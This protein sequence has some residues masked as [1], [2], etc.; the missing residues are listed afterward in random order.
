MNN[1][2]ND[3]DKKGKGKKETSEIKVNHNPSYNGNNKNGSFT[4]PYYQT[5]LNYKNDVNQYYNI[6][7]HYNIDQ[8]NNNLGKSD[9][10]KG[11]S[12]DEGSMRDNLNEPT[13]NEAQKLSKNQWRNLTD[14]FRE[15]SAG[16]RASTSQNNEESSSTIQNQ[17]QRS[18]IGGITSFAKNIAKNLRRTEEEEPDDDH[19][20]HIKIHFHV[21]LP[22]NISGMGEPFVI[23][24][25]PELGEWSEFKVKLRQFKRNF[26]T[27]TTYWYSEPI[28]IPVGRFQNS[29]I[30]RY[31]YVIR[32]KK[33][34]DMTPYFYEGND[35]RDDRVLVMYKNQFDVW[36]IGNKNNQIPNVRI[37]DYM[38][39][40]IIYNSINP[41]NFKEAILEYDNILKDNTG[42]T[43]SVTN[44]GFIYRYKQE[45][46]V[47][48]RLFLIFLLGHCSSSNHSFIGRTEL[49]RDFNPDFLFEVIGEI[50][51]DTFPSKNLR[52]VS[53]GIELLVR[54]DID[55]RSFIWL[56][57]FPIAQYID[58]KYSFLDS[59]SFNYDADY[60]EQF[61][62]NL[63]L[64]IPY[65]DTIIDEDVYAKI[66]KWLINHC[67]MKM[68]SIIWELIVHSEKIDNQICPYLVE[69]VGRLISKYDS[70]ELNK[71]FNELPESIRTVVTEP[72]R[73]K[74]IQLLTHG[75]F[76]LWG[77]ARAEAVFTL[78]NSLHLRW[79]KAEY[80]TVLEIMSNLM[81]YMLLN[82]FPILL[83]NW[84]DKSK[85]TKDEKISQICIQWY[86]RLMDQMA[87]MSSKTTSNEE[88][89]VTAVFKNLSDV[90]I[91]NEKSVMNE[92][93]DITYNRIKHSSEFLI[94]S[95][96]T[97][98]ANMDS[99]A[100]LVFKKVIKEKINPS[101]Q[102]HDEYLLKKMR[103]ICGCI[104]NDLNIPNK[105]CEEILSHIM[106]CLKNNSS[107]IDFEEFS[108]RLHL[109]LF[110]SADF[111]T[112]ILRATGNVEDFH[113]HPHIKAAK[114]AMIKLA[115]MIND[116]FIDLHLLQ[117]L[118][119]RDD[120]F[121]HYYLNSAKSDNEIITRK[122]LAEVRKKCHDYE[123]KLNML[124]DF[125]KT[126]CQKANDV[127]NY[128][129]E[130]K[131]RSNNL[132]KISLKE[133]L[134]SDHWG[135]H[136]SIMSIVEDLN[137]FIK[138]QTFNNIFRKQITNQEDINVRFIA[139]TLI[140]NALEEYKA[141]C[142]QYERWENLE[143]SKATSFWYK[144]H[145]FDYEL[146]LMLQFCRKINTTD[147][148]F[149]RTIRYLSEV[150]DWKER[151][152][153]LSM[154]LIIFK[155][156]RL[157]NDWLEAGFADLN[158]DLSLG[159][160]SKL[161]E[162]F[163]DK[164]SGFNSNSW[165]FIKELSLSDEFIGFLRIIAEHDM[166]NLINGV[167]E[168]SDTRLIQ[169]D[170]VSSLIQVKQCLLP[171]MT[172]ANLT[173]DRYLKDLNEIIVRNPS[174]A[175]KLTL[176]NSNSM[177]LQNMYK[178]ISNRGEVTKEK[179][180][181]AVNIGVY[182]FVKEEKDDECTL[183]L[184]YHS[185]SSKSDGNYDVNALQDLRGRALLISKPGGS[186]DS[187]NG[188]IDNTKNIMEE[189][190]SQFDIAQNII[191]IMNKLTQL[192]HFEY[193]KYNESAKGTN[194]LKQISD[195]LK[196]ELESWEDIVNKAQEN[197][198]YLTF[199][200]SRHILAFYDFYT[201]TERQ[202]RI[203]EICQT[204]VSFVNRKAILP[205]G[206]RNRGF[207]CR[208]DEYYQILKEIGDRLKDIFEKLPKNP[209]LIKG[210]GERVVSDVVERGKLFVAACNDKFRVPNIIMSF[211]ANHGS[212]PEPWQL[213]I[214][215]SSTTAEELS[216]FI[217]RCFFASKNGYK[218][219]LFCIANL[220]LL[221]FELQYDL[222]NN[223][224]THMTEVKDYYL[225]LICCSETGMNHHILD[226]FSEN[227]H[228]T[229]GLSDA[230]MK[231]IYRE[232]CP[233]VVCVTSELSGQGKTEW[234]KQES[235]RRHLVLKS[236]LISDG[237][238]YNS[239]VKQLK[240]F[241]IRHVNSLHINI[242]SAD[243][244]GEVNIFL[245]Q[246]ITLGIVSNNSDIA[247]RIDSNV[248]IEV[249][250]SFD[251]YL[252]KS[253]PFIN[254]LDRPHLVWNVNR[255]IVSQEIHNPIQIVCN[256]LNLYERG[257]LDKK[258]IFFRSESS[259]DDDEDIIRTPLN[260]ELCQQ[261]L[262]KYF[263]K[264][265]DAGISS[266]RFL[267]IFINVLADQLIRLSS[268]SFFEV[269][270][271]N[272]MIREN[273]VRSTLLNTL[274]DVSKDFATKSIQTRSAQL[275]EI[276]SGVEIAQL[277]NIAQWDDSNHLLVFFMSQTPDSI[278]SLY[279]DKTKV[280]N[281]VQ[282]LLKS[283]YIDTEEEWK[284]L[285]YHTMSSE[286]LLSTLECLARK[287]MHKID[288]PQ[289]ALSVDNLLKMALMLLRT[290]ANI[291]VVVCGEAGCGKTS[292]IGFLAGVVEVEFRALNLHAGITEQN[293]KAFMK[294]SD[295][296]AQN[297]EIWLFF[298]EINTCNH[299]GLLADLIAHRMLDGKPI[300]PNIR[301]FAACNP[302]RIRKKSISNVG[303]K[304][305]NV[306]FE[307]QSR[308]VYEVKPLPDQILDYVWDY[309]R[310][311]PNDEKIYI[312][313]MVN[314]QLEG[315]LGS[316]MLA[317]LL[318][319]SQEFIRNVEESYS[320]S[321]RDV[322]RAIKLVKFFHNSLQNRPIN[323]KDNKKSHNKHPN[324][325]IRSYILALGLCYQ[326]RLY[327]RE[328]RKKY[329]VEMCK[330]FLREKLII[331]EQLFD[332]V[333]KE[334]QMD[335]IKRMT[336]P[337]NTAFNEALLENVLVIIVCILNRI[338]LFIVGSPGSSKSLAIRLVH[339]NL[340]GSDSNDE[341]FRKLPQVFF[342][343]HQGSSSSTSDG[344]EKVFQ[345]AKA[346]QETSSK[347]FPVISVVLLDEVGLAET[348]P[349]NPLKV[350]HSLLEP[351]Y[352]ADGPTVS[353]VGISNWRLD[354]SKSSRALLVQRP[355]FDLDDLI[356]T[357]VRLLDKNNLE[358]PSSE[359]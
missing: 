339:Q 125:Y 223:I 208:R 36:M 298:D 331:R 144:V 20:E 315:T 327:D 311:Q 66:A 117:N 266:F 345:K 127:E 32:K 47:H 272:L 114:I 219:C 253:L 33:N 109:S 273:N 351:S 30:V 106:T 54:R 196:K 264:R 67:N 19:S 51:P 150:D 12:T 348:S 44:F 308:L 221:D 306:R 137:I 233:K 346:Y 197:C 355:K 146:K 352:P 28:K 105:L 249:A 37:N 3:D 62:K 189:F 207:N 49:S 284:L 276:A 333:I 161:F 145:N 15:N 176:C 88:S 241:H 297:K 191:T 107:H 163:D 261:L 72:Y 140:R 65:I 205:Y 31:K 74:T 73:K 46:S 94:F 268:S 139:K 254:C 149:I 50:Q 89:Y 200:P 76:S 341:Y 120:N 343:P 64:I 230:A 227:V 234:I 288:Y 353:V 103:V 4:A 100:I 303:L 347:E 123:Q 242:I 323:Q 271:L 26:Q 192:G 342:I 133:T 167:D 156:R 232:L 104:N 180:Q 110:D 287:T 153:Y 57:I 69:R 112:V 10:D 187:G 214:C 356:E 286:Q 55:R 309:G 329:R 318:F 118:I 159:K 75:Q 129:D 290:R 115:T 108:T 1:Q 90:S 226:Q 68:F 173:L 279:R 178:T 301:L 336:C 222:V 18:L 164:F 218:N 296:K 168:H 202:T 119:V 131:E 262:D 170:T 157:E 91:I 13:E 101:L 185:K 245:F 40:E 60:T 25:I 338:P 291:P 151:L 326:S 14:N 23:G 289:Y 81:D 280:P 321:L 83:K 11:N 198:Y 243:N 190:V 257:E 344:I 337:P 116:G 16:Q 252:L 136:K 314:D 354:N 231:A 211:Y 78:L 263:F 169:E 193:R 275:Q 97:K 217:K 277:K 53:K 111:W 215:T 58:P 17:S 267:D 212:Y 121:L 334:E 274:F 255:L 143:Y 225:A 224:R 35:E 250:S 322:K 244:P 265:I 2:E 63:D 124:N 42:L 70:A 201:K 210:S 152:K 177:A 21:H 228:P 130:L 281:N 236:F 186:Y 256:Y 203:P 84:I 5:G 29:S 147:P 128:L 316:P 166:K 87:T 282:N 300:H 195:K 41:N 319:V 27:Y 77:K 24:S 310:L 324:I 328:L 349:F 204:L 307:E 154:V 305:K 34:K 138:S 238:N 86:K 141:I 162:T 229:I 302:Y 269:H 79:T 113:S 45:M 184:K 102:N 220:E 313:I 216:I 235:H 95:A 85:D 99:R 240:E 213:L 39:L 292:L 317:D 80:L 122:K 335:Y 295:E 350:L 194:K 59:I 259:T 188:Q 340:R 96:A 320:V 239:L 181:N 293:I 148:G 155:V 182:Y 237:A 8:Y 43:R 9:K 6:N 247:S 285:D 82:K 304:P 183:T 93:M 71:S 179:I 358:L 283:Q 174:L 332:E 248:F 199:Y 172:K 325:V 48:K 278:C 251:Q 299:I 132:D 246:L 165:A 171:L 312:Q 294:E 52:T 209:R 160:L 260:R 126:F 158:D 258:D 142:K 7:Q 38:F 56:N 61:F 357:A 134:S 270:N 359:F 175:S 92:L 135:F 98:V 330:I 22:P 206:Q